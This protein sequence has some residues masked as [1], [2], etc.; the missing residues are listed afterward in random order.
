MNIFK[1]FGL[2]VFKI[3]MSR[4]FFDAM[5]YCS[6]NGF[7][8]CQEEGQISLRI[9]EQTLYTEKKCL[10]FYEGMCFDHLLFSITFLLPPLRLAV[11]TESKTPS[12][13]N[14]K[15]IVKIKMAKSVIKIY[16]Q[17]V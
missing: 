8:S 17:L 13:L 16:S 11:K 12:D 6:L 2:Y 14:Q 5:Q 10:S 9:I 1:D 3:Y 7:T 4:V 15:E